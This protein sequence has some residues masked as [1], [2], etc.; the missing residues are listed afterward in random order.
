M[1]LPNK[2]TKWY[3]QIIAAA[4]SRTNI[5]EYVEKH[6]IIPKS[7]GGNN[8]KENLVNLSAREHFICHR[9]LVKMLNGDAKNK[10]IY[11]LWRMSVNGA[12]CQKRFKPNA[13]TYELIRAQ[14]G[15]LRKGQKNSE[16][17]KQ[18]I[19]VAN[20]GK[21]AWNKGILRTE[22]EK[23]LMSARRKEVANTGTVWNYGKTHSADTILKMKEK[24]KQRT[25]YLCPHC[26]KSVAGANY[27]RWHGD[28]CKHRLLK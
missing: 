6:H 20:K 9:L 14:F 24:A 1:Y 26:D 2:Y 21:T 16:I 25:R 11:A 17:S 18:K 27:F 8:R 12:H 28:N 10:M 5:P 3:M 19:S 7:L 22:S 15:Y 23:A 4:T 13:R